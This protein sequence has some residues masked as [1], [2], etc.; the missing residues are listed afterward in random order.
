MIIMLSVILFY[1]KHLFVNFNKKKKILKYIFF[2]YV[3]SY[4]PGCNNIFIFLVCG[5]DGL[6]IN[7]DRHDQT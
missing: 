5:C 3:P 4:I 6:G 2:Y 7:N 1:Q